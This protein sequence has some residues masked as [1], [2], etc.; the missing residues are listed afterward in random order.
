MR[1]SVS[2]GQNDWLI[3]AHHRHYDDDCQVHTRLHVIIDSSW[4]VGFNHYH[5]CR[6]DLIIIYACVGMHACTYDV[7]CGGMA[8]CGGPGFVINLSCGVARAA[9][10]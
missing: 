5:H 8:L 7:R 1:A 4:D 2:Q 3:V 9:L 10:P 6:S